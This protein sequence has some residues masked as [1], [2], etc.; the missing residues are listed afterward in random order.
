[1]AEQ[2]TKTKNSGRVAQG[3]KLAALNKE[4][5]EKLRQAGQPAELSTELSK[6]QPAVSRTVKCVVLWRCC[7]RSRGCH[8]VLF[9]SK[10]KACVSSGF[11]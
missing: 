1:M 5:K 10:K 8:C 3:H 9:L 7:Y 4:R 2:V 6:E 11:Y